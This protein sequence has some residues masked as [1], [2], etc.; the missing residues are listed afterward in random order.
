MRVNEEKI[1]NRRKQRKNQKIRKVILTVLLA[2]GAVI[3]AGAAMHGVVFLKRKMRFI[4]RWR[5]SNYV[6][7]N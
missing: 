6:R 1:S 2:L 4:K 7:K 5:P 3:I